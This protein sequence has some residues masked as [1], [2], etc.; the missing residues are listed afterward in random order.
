MGCCQASIIEQD[1]QASPIGSVP[2]DRT[3]MSA[4]KAPIAL[5]LIS[6]GSL[7]PPKLTPCFGKK[8]TFE[9]RSSFDSKHLEIS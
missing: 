1:L 9:E 2:G 4:R 5:P 6:E 3:A 8:F 7:P